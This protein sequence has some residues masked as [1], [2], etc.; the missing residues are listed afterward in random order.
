M[1]AFW[2]K[3]RHWGP[4]GRLIQPFWSIFDD[5]ENRR[6]FDAFLGRQKID[7][8]RPW[9]AKG[10]PC[11]DRVLSSVARGVPYGKKNKRLKHHVSGDPDTPMGR[12]PGEFNHIG[13]SFRFSRSGARQ[14]SRASM[15]ADFPSKIVWNI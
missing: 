14:S 5:S 9:S 3:S 1:H 13:T 6:F 2:S 15:D 10:S 4:K 7:K 12:R 8:M 11:K